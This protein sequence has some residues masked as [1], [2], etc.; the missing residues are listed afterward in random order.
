[1]KFTV[2]DLGVKGLMVM[3]HRGGSR[4]ETFNQNLNEEEVKVIRICLLA[5]GWTEIA[6]GNPVELFTTS[7]AG[8]YDAYVK[9][10][11]GSRGR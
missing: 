3:E 2:I 10:W 4:W 6:A 5:W 7:S 8:Y 1:M 11:M 9:G